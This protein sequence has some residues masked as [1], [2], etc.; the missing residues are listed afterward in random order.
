MRIAMAPG[1]NHI[2]E[3]RT[4]MGQRPKGSMKV[5]TQRPGRKEEGEGREGGEG[6]P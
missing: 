3:N 6:D 4:S 2:S 1:R 5:R